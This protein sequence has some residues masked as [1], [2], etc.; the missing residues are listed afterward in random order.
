MTW[1]FTMQDI[2][3][4]PDNHKGPKWKRTGESGEAL[5]D[6]I[7]RQKFQVVTLYISAVQFN[8]LYVKGFYIA[9]A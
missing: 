9:K 1:L 8:Q 7:S 3:K 2:Q 5:D 6:F 4:A